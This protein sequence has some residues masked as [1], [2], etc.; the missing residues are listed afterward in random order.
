MI[1]ALALSILMAGT[2]AAHHSIA[3]TYD[4]SKPTEYQATIVQ[5]TWMNPHATAIATVAIAGGG[6]EA[7][8][9]EIGSPNAMLRAG[10]KRDYL[11]QGDV[12]TILAVPAKDG[13]KEAYAR[14]ITWADGHVIETLPDSFNQLVGKQQ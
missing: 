3:G 14:R 2:L 7:W 10:L 12:V 6:S 4:I 1:R 9:F 5:V 11:K 8:T 13:A